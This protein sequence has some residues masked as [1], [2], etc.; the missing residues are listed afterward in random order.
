MMRDGRLRDGVA[1]GNVTRADRADTSQLAKDRQAR[2][3]PGR[4]QQENL[5]IGRALHGANILMIGYL[6][7]YEYRR[8]SPA[9]LTRRLATAIDYD[10]LHS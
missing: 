8:S 1:A 10:D 7:K 6:D 3:V 5:G 4:L 2:G 9:V